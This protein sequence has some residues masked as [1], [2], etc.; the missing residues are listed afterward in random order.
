VFKSLTRE[1]IHQRA[2]AFTVIADQI[3]Q[4]SKPRHLIRELEDKWDVR[5]RLV[6]LKEH[7]N[8]KI[9]IIEH[10]GYEIMI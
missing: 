9:W 6:V 1:V 8:K 5:I 2:Q 4:S 7:L 10:C 3:S